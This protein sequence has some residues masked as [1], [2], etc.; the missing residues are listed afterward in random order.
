MPISRDETSMALIAEFQLRSPRLPLVDV[1]AAVPETTLQLEGGEQSGSGSFV[2]FIRATGSTFNG[3]DTALEESPLVEE[4][5]RVSEVGSMRLYQLVMASRRPTAVDELAL[6]KT[7]SESL[8]FLPNG[9][10]LRQR[11]ADR[12]EF[13]KLRDLCREFGLSFEL[14]RLYSATSTD[15]DLIGLTDK[16]REALLTAYESGYFAVPRRASMADV[17]TQLD[18]SVPSLAERLHRAEAHLIEH[19]FYS[20]VY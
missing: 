20:Q 14:D 6:G 4:H 17:A 3:L 10:R 1:A 7:F 9:W 19:F 18:I 2:F 8:T 5:Y 15:E 11:F 12:Q 16:Q 13:A